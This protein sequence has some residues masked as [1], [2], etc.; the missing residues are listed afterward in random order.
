MR[1]YTNTTIIGNIT[2]DIELKT[3]S[4][5]LNVATFTIA[6]NDEKDE[7]SYIDCVAWNKTAETIAKYVR[8]GEPFLVQG[9]LKQRSWE[10]DGIKRSKIEVLVQTFMFMPKSDR[11]LTQG[12]ALSAANDYV[13][14]DIEDKEIDLSAIP[15]N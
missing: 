8:K 2:K 3:T 4:G 1:G 14:E 9:K 10:K 13:P 12:E 11:K 5:G 7:T 15:F 6:V